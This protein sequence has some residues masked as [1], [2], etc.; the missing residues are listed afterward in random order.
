[1]KSKYPKVL[2]RAGGRTLIE[3]VLQAARALSIDISVVVG[4]S[5]ERVKAAV[6][7][8]K[9][10]DQKEQLGTGHAVLAARES[11]SGYSGDMLVIPGDVPLISAA[12][13]EA[14][15]KFHREGGYRASVLTAEIENPHGYGRIVRRKSHELE[16]I[17]EHRDATPEIL[18]IREINSSIYVFH[19]PALFESLTKIRNE[20][21]QREYYLTDVIGIL[22]AQKEKVGAFKV[23]SAEEI[24]G[25][26][27]RQELAEVDRVMRRKKCESLMADG[28]T[29]V[30]PATTYI[31]ADVEIGADTVIYPSVQ[32]YGQT[33]IEKT[34]RF[35]RS[36]ASPTQIERAV[37]CS[38]DPSLW[39]AALV[40]MSLSAHM[41]T[42]GWKRRS[43]MARKWA[44]SLRSRRAPSAPER[45][46]CIS[47]I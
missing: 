32:I 3:H 14:F 15:V 27:T 11:F 7:E 40:K 46:R 45:R 35:I 26:N 24:M 33:V 19:A 17:V 8:V 1:M 9:F 31:D 41:L 12:T 42:C 39:T 29:I 4:H 36:A 43:T 47:H 38:K 25:I 18:D 28:V 5:A 20:N 37:L 13:L 2:H 21:S 6:S 44:I 16:A 22:V 30:D 23:K 34:P 10:V